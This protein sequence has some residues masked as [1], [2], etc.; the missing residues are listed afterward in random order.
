MRM[1][2]ASAALFAR[3]N[4]LRI[5]LVI[6]AAALVSA[7][8]HFLP[9]LGT[10]R[11]A[12][13][14]PVSGSAKT[15]K[16]IRYLYPEPVHGK[17]RQYVDELV[18]GPS[19]YRG[20]PLFTPGTKVMYCF[21]REKTLYVVLSREAVLQSGGAPSIEW[22]TELLKKN[23]RKNFSGIKNIELFID[24]AHISG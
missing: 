22:G 16:E 17:I 10:D 24:G 13:V 3:R 14:F 18:L 20:R 2:F 19:F 6:V 4:R 21:L 12:F 23:I 11:R 8:L 15:K 9:H 7:A 5:A 1:N